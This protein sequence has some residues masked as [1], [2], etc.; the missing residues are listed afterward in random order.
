MRI[1]GIDV[2][3]LPSH[4]R[5]SPSSP[6]SAEHLIQRPVEL[7]DGRSEDPDHDGR[8]DRGQEDRGAEDPPARHAPVNRE[9]DDQR[10][11]DEDRDGEREDRV[12]PQGGAEDR[13]APEQLEVVQAD[14]LRRADPVPAR[15]GVVEDA[16]ERIGDEHAHERHCGRRVKQAP[17]PLRAMGPAP[18]SGCLRRGQ[19]FSDL[20]PLSTF[21][22]ALSGV[23]LPEN[24]AWSCW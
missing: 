21:C 10:D 7:Q 15:K 24:A 11:D 16:R 2:F 9:G 12:V 23:V 1:R 22:I 3:A 6:M 5:C 18:H 20:R 4:S 13:V 19:G 8:V 14:P 17:Q